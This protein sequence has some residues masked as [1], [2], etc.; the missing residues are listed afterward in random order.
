MPLRRVELL[1]A[2]AIPSDHRAD[3][4][5]LRQT[6]ADQGIR[7][8]PAEGDALI[9]LPGAVAGLGV[10][11]HRLDDNDTPCGLLD[12]AGFYSGLLRG[13]SDSEMD[14][15]VR[16]RQRGRL[17]VD[18]DPVSLVRSLVEYLPPETRR[19]AGALA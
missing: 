16:E 10:L 18:R 15:F 7:V 8:V 2:T 3:L 5:R 9:A 6:L 19:Q 11:F 13:A 4:E 1:E 17:V 12:A 14:R